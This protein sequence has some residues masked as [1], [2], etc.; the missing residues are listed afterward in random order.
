MI[1]W[2][3]YPIEHWIKLSHYVK[4]LTLPGVL[5]RLPHLHAMAP[6]Y[7]RLMV[8]ASHESPDPI[9][10]IDHAQIFFVRTIEYAFS[11]DEQRI[12]ALAEAYNDLTQ[13]VDASD[14]TQLL[15]RVARVVDSSRG[16]LSA[17]LPFMYQDPDYA[18]VST[19][20]LHYATALPLKDE[21][22]LTGPKWCIWAAQHHALEAGDVDMAVGMISGIL[23]LGDRRT[24]PILDK[25]WEW[26]GDDGQALLAQH[27]CTDRIDASTVEFWLRWLED[28][29]E[30][31][32]EDLGIPAGALARIPAIS[33]NQ[34]V[35]DVRRRFPAPYNLID[36]DPDDVQ[37]NPP[38][39]IVHQWSIEE[40]ARVIE[41]RLR[42]LYVR[43]NEPAVMPMVLEAWGLEVGNQQASF[44]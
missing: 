41:P 2:D 37:Q 27:A 39:Q 25:C 14:R 28:V 15:V 23:A 9:S 40:F 33:P 42:W 6:V 10:S 18:V 32:G 7:D 8:L 20:S 35:R 17:L 11:G 38:V 43:E 13:R 3:A 22:P 30:D 26:L 19:A 12:A 36:L 4:V 5:D 16:E 24:I 34:V 29:D 44:S 31:A 1:D 21:D